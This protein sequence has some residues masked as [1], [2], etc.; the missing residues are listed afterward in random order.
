VSAARGATAWST[1]SVVDGRYR[2]LGLL[3]AGGMGVVYLVRH[4]SWGIDLAVKCPQEAPAADPSGHRGFVAEAE[5]WMRLGAHP[6]VCCCHYVRVLDGVPRAFVEYVPGGSLD[7]WIADRRL[8]SGDGST[9]LGRMLDVALQAAWGLGHAHAAGLVHR[10]VKP[11]NILLEEAVGAFPT[12]K[13]TDFG[14]ARSLPR[15]PGAAP[16][17]RPIAGGG[18]TRRYASPEQFRREA[19]DRRTDVFSFAVALLEMFAGGASWQIGPAAGP[20]LEQL[21]A[22]GVREPGI[23]ALPQELADLLERCLRERPAERPP[24]MDAVAEELAEFSAR[25]TGT[26]AARPRPEAAELRADELNNR[27]LS[28]LDLGRTAEA[29]SAFDEAIAADPRNARVGYNAALVRWRGGA[30]SDEQVLA[31]LEAYR[32]D[33]EDPLQA[34]YLL[35]QVHLERGD[36]AAARALL[37]PAAAGKPGGSDGSG[38]ARALRAVIESGRVADARGLAVSRMPWHADRVWET[39]M[40]KIRVTP[41]GR[42]AVQACDDGTVRVWEVASGRCLNRLRGHTR[43]VHAVA[44]TPDGRFAASR[45]DDGAVRLWDL[46]AGECL[47]TFTP[48]GAEGIVRITGLEITADGRTVIAAAHTRLLAWEVPSAKP[49]WSVEAHHGDI[50]LALSGDGRLA[51]SS[52]HDEAFDPDRKGPGP[53]GVKIW[54]ARTGERLHTLATEPGV[55][56]AL[57]LDEHGEKVCVGRYNQSIKVWRVADGRILADLRGHPDGFPHA[58]AF[59]QDGRLVAGAGLDQFGFSSAKPHS[60]RVWELATA[61]C[62]R[63]YQGHL[64]TVHAVAF[65]PGTRQLVSLSQ[66]DTARFWELPGRYTAPLQVSRP[67]R[68]AELGGLDQRARALVGR[69]DAALRSERLCLAASL[70]AQAR[71][72]PGHARAPEI[73]EAWQALGRRAARGALRSV[74]PAAAIGGNGARRAVLSP[75]GSTAATSSGDGVVRLWDLR[76]GAVCTGTLEAFRGDASAL[77]LTEDGRRLLAATPGGDIGVWDLASGER[78]SFL[79]GRETLGARPVRF[80]PD[81]RLALA[82]GPDNGVR[83][84]D[85]ESARLVRTFAAGGYAYVDK[86]GALCLGP[87]LRTVVIGRDELVSAWD[88]ETGERISDLIGHEAMVA[89]AE[90]SADGRLALTCGWYHDRTIRIWDVPTGS[91]IKVLRT[92]ATAH[93]ARLSA[94]GRFALT[95]GTDAVA[96]IWDLRSGECV[97]TLTGHGGEVGQVE[98]T[99][100]ARFALTADDGGAQVWHLDWELAAFEPADWNESAAPYLEMFARRFAPGRDEE[101]FGRLLSTLADAGLGWLRPEGVRSRLRALRTRSGAAGAA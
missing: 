43:A 69:A 72:L 75:D 47:R 1:G 39:S 59:S 61:R 83:L 77:A 24:S 82:A 44:V 9:A 86:P 27:A 84:W 66:D 33:A 17:L 91:C 97:R 48:R 64:D 16:Q 5:T 87:D 36:L 92:P 56:R 4:L 41:D 54:D 20:A 85:L 25:I 73:L 95:G 2:V 50:V 101:E 8:Y 10:D 57:S 26:V 63:S 99:P 98:L 49:L 34:S 67:R 74:W 79:E 7:R 55:V 15:D 51:A 19:L 42:L 76:S 37:R 30:I 45:G 6:N 3:G 52:G 38:E 46:G 60:V 31:A 68:P 53:A 65:L 28:L 29:E 40:L 94:D 18:M 62:L 12:A 88:A 89:A 35:A 11:A 13:L 96:R 90:I 58:L 81:G 78:L 21:R 70:L 71:E 23:P 14:L 80:S 93:C 100:D 32:A 22:R